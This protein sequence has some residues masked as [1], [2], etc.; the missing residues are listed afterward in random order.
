MP[1]HDRPIPDPKH[2]LEPKPK[3]EPEPK[4]W[5]TLL[6]ALQFYTAIPIYDPN[7]PPTRGEMSAG[8]SLLPLLGLMLGLAQVGL[9]WAMTALFRSPVAAA[10]AA[11]LGWWLLP[12]VVS[13]G[14][15]EDGLA[16]FAD[17]MLG[18]A[19]RPRRLKIMK[20]SR[21]GAFGVLALIADALIGI[22]G[23]ALIAAMAEPSFVAG[24]LLAAAVLPRTAALLL[25]LPLGYVRKGCGHEG[26]GHKACN[27]KG[28][29]E[30]IITTTPI[31]LG[32]SFA[33]WAVVGSAVTAALLGS[34]LLAGLIA[35]TAIAYGGLWRWL[36]AS[37]GGYTGD[38]LGAAIKIITLV[39]ISTCAAIVG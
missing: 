29:A 35:V 2:K 36:K 38:C 16:D 28:S 11:A 24:A 15:H 27:H 32:P 3:L 4:P 23:V 34:V 13:R 33:L 8:H 14:L 30:G 9:W 12:I 20:D 31:K 25:T 18:G 10:G 39:I 37:L 26:C 1:P 5:P 21:I 17:G 6:A 22:G 19:T 7:R